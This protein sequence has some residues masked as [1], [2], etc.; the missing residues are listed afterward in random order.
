MYLDC[1]LIIRGV[2]LNVS[3]VI[4]VN[5]LSNQAIK[6]H[7]ILKLKVHCHLF[8]NLDKFINKILNSGF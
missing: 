6:M 7:D 2:M 1:I 4:N 3:K 5:Y 8:I